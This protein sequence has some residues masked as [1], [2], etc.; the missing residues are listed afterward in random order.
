MTQHPSVLVVENHAATRELLATLLDDAG[1]AVL[2]AS[3]GRAALLTL[4]QHR[5]DAVLTDLHMPLLDGDGLL[6]AIRADPVLYD[7][8]VLAVTAHPDRVRAHFDALVTKPFDA[9]QL[10]AALASVITRGQ[11]P[12]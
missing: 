1:Y 8:P 7:L 12:A 5:P 4:A 2:T 11:P 6:A 10:L 3:D 9:G